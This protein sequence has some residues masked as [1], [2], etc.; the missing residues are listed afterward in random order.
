[1]KKILAALAATF[2]G[3]ML[4]S[5]ITVKADSYTYTI[6][7]KEVASPDAYTWEKSVRAED[8]GLDAMTS[9]VDVFYLNEKIYI[10][11]N[12]KIVITDKEFNMLKVITD[13][14][15]N[16]V[17]TAIAAPKGIFVTSDEEIYFTEEAMGLVIHLDKNGEF[18]R[19]LSDPHI[20]SIENI[21]YQ[22]T[23][24]VV[25]DIGRI[26]VKAKSVY[27]GIIELDPNGVFNRFIGANEVSPS[28]YQRFRRAIST[29][30]QIEQMSLWLPTD[31][32][33][34]TLD[35]EG[36]ILASVRDNKTDTP[37]KKLNS[38][39]KDVLASYEYIVSPRG[40]YVRGGG[41][42]SMLTN[43]AAAE[44]GRFAVLDANFARVFVYAPDGILLYILGGSGKLNGQLSSPVDLCF[45]EDRIL[46]AD[47]VANSIEVF[48]PT[49]YG[50]LINTALSYQSEYDYDTAASY[51]EQVYNINPNHIAANM[52]LG[53][54]RLRSGD[55]EGALESFR[56]TGERTSW[57]SAFEKVR[58]AWL[59]K[60]LVTTVLIILGVII[61]LAVLKRWFDKKDREGH[62]ENNGFVKVLKK[63]KYTVITWPMYMMS[64]PFKAFDDMKYE[65]AGSL[66]F[67]I[68]LMV[69]CG[70]LGLVNARYKGFL[71][72]TQDINNINVPLI[73][74]SSVMA[75]L[76]FVIANWASGVLMDGK[77]TLKNVFKFTMYSMYPYIILSFLAVF[78]SRVC[79]YEETG[80]VMVV[81]GIGLFLNAFYMF[82]AIVTVHQYSFSKGIGSVI[83]S[84]VGMAIVIF[85][86]LLF[87]SLLTGFVNDM[88][89][90]VDEMTLYL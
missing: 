12:G 49:E 67:A 23:K 47:N 38:S 22:P 84:A 63:I 50:T 5:P 59:E 35:A 34:I 16:G 65:D 45:M 85:I 70:W 19:A 11:M 8:H 48:R 87:A 88:G 73:L 83:A 36:Y 53:K 13:Y 21:T 76:I 24:V 52:G 15:N 39:G 71:M 46:V 33:D 31:Y 64:S 2:T 43:I 61:V 1:M 79:V 72:N 14:V 90:I 42:N 55:Y 40:D 4:L 37:I 69:L 62:F 6:Y 10:L 20:K 60:N 86:I 80:M 27:E 28:L 78:L 26:Y 56:R 77:G 66:P 57:S 18:I 74:V 29:E 9:L 3:L 32:S 7:D 54:Y 68:V 44:D 58:E 30:K 51:W 41:T 82:V 25:D 89:T 75:R 17:K 81:S